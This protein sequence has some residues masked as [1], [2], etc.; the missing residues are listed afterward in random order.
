MREP[1][2]LWADQR[3][4]RRQRSEVMVRRREILTAFERQRGSK[5]ITL[6]HRQEVW[7][8]EP[9]FITIEDSEFVLAQ[10]KHTPGDVPIDII[11]HTPGGLAL[12]AE[13]IAMAL[14]HHPAPVTAIVPF[15]A[16]SG[17]TLIALAADEIVMERFTTLGPVDPQVM[18][19]PA[20]ALLRVLAAKPLAAV[21]DEMIVRAEIARLAVANVRGFV[22]WLLQDRL[23]P[24]RAAEL[25]EFLTGGYLAHDTPIT[26]QTLAGFGLSVREGVPLPIYDLFST[27]AFGVCRRPCLASYEQAGIAPPAA[28][29]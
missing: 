7:E 28:G 24:Q 5:A 20:G 1:W 16:M 8:D 13:M 18:G 2:E 9:S 17:G 10:I 6:I 19:Y 26:L 12:A 22:Q 14:K 25:A 15:Y 29:S 4:R 23:P 11:M 27:C 21:S 3:E